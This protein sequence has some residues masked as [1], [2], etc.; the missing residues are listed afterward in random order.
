MRKYC[1]M[2]FL[3]VLLVPVLAQAQPTV[4][5][6]GGTQDPAIPRNSVYTLLMSDGLTFLNADLEEVTVPGLGYNVIYAPHDQDNQEDAE[7][8]DLIIAHESVGS[9][10]VGPTVYA[11]LDVPYLAIEQVLAAGRADRAGGVWFTPQSGV[12]CCDAGDYE[13]E[14]IDNSHPITAIYDEGQ[15]IEITQNLETAQVAGI[16]P[17]SLA[18]AAT[19]LAVAG[20][21]TGTEKVSL[22]VA[23]AG[24]EG[25]V[26][27]D[28]APP[29]AGADPVPARRAF[30]GYHEMVQVFTNDATEPDLIAITRDGAILFQ[31]VIQWLVGLPVTADGTEEGAQLP[32]RVGEWSIH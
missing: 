8:S 24:A 17:A 5:F 21:T 1:A 10:D 16:N 13:L 32:T 2:V 9:G 11:T 22:A 27:N 18:P 29:P 20:F 28:D 19:P 26:G 6:I 7:A 25:L 15:I 12:V 30:L 31:R 14:I 3:F 4:Y 23:E